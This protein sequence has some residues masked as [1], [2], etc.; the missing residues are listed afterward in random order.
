MKIKPIVLSLLIVSLFSCR[1]T[2]EEPQ[3]SDQAFLSFKVNGELKEFEATNSPMG[4]SFD[5]DG[6]F[7]L[8][9]FSVLAN[10]TDGSKNFISGF[11]RNETLFETNEI[12]EMQNPILFQGIPMVRIQLTYSN[13]AGELYNAVLFQEDFPTLLATD[14]ARFQ[15]TEIT[16]N[17]VKGEFSG[18]L[19]GPVFVTN[20][21]GDTELR[22]TEGKF[23]IPLLRNNLP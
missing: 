7:Y 12:L 20:G 1:E 10:P 13:E 18:N 16:E 19:L 3:N 14:D 22:I 4:F 9:N 17:W 15:F 11:L 21:R 23:S 8:A 6:P 2:E 5:P